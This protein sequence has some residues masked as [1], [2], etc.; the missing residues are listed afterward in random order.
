MDTY[1]SKNRESIRAKRREFYIQNCERIKA[2][3]R[4]Y[5]VKHR[6]ECA[7]KARERYHKN[8]EEIVARR[9]EWRVKNPEKIAALNRKW[10]VKN[11]EA[12]LAKQHERYVNNRAIRS[13]KHRE[14]YYQNREQSLAR[15]REWFKRNR[16]K[17]AAYALKWHHE[18]VKTNPL[19][20]AMRSCRRRMLLALKGNFKV[21]RTFDLIG[22]TPEQLREHLQSRFTE[23]MQWNNHGL[24]KGKWHVDHIIPCASFDLSQE[25]EQRRCFHWTNLQPLWSHH[26][27]VKGAR[28]VKNAP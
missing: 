26:N 7:A 3:S 20:K 22:C 2:E 25:S 15:H 1:Y 28:L 24:G 5:R 23:G 27:L 12:D 18:R 4:E 13:A 16:E 8:R 11:R 17:M 14:Y 6:E 21:G 19:Y 9:R 10:R